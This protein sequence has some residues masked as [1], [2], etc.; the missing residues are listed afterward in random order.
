[1]ASGLH[2]FWEF[3][4]SNSNIDDDC[5]NPENGGNFS[6]EEY[7]K[8]VFDRMRTIHHKAKNFETFDYTAIR[9]FIEEAYEV[10]S[11]AYTKYEND[12]TASDETPATVEMSLGT[13]ESLAFRGRILFD[14]HL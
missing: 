3:T 2:D 6:P 9:L 10:I 4:E 12:E 5:D 13:L 8:I 7:R 1:M 14:E 11:D